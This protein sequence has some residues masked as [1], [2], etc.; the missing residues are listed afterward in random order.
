MTTQYIYLTFYMRNV[1]TMT[2][3]EI[4][5]AKWT[6]WWEGFTYPD[7]PYGHLEFSVDG[8]DGVVYTY[9]ISMERG[10]TH[11]ISGK[12]FKNQ[13]YLSPT[14]RR[15]GVTLKDRNR[16]IKFLE[17]TI[18]NDDSFDFEYVKRYLCHR[19]MITR[20]VSY[21]F[22]SCIFNTPKKGTW[23]CIE[24]IVSAL[25]QARD[26]RIISKDLD[27]LTVTVQ[28]IWNRTM[29]MGDIVPPSN[30]RNHSIPDNGG[31]LENIELGNSTIIL[32]RNQQYSTIPQRVVDDEEEEE[33]E[34]DLFD[35]LY[36]S[37]DSEH[38]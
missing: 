32:P 21:C 16:I 1:H 36:N 24:L 10:K 26:S 22:E 9:G 3:N 31:V 2:E 8:N 6:A 12:G 29:G 5:G 38:V 25:Q 33:Q 35:L 17:N 15:I 19:Y 23:C 28:D 27:P 37:D 14:C 18:K 20:W 7:L 4:T 30:V 34:I 11:K 13:S